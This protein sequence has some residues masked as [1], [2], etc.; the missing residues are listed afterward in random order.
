MKKV[1][2]LLW[3]VFLFIGLLAYLSAK[4]YSR[5]FGDIG[6]EAVLFTLLNGVEG[7]ADS[8]IDEY[9]K[10]S[11]YPSF[12]ITL[13]VFLVLIFLLGISVKAHIC[14]IVN[15]RYKLTIFP[16]PERLVTFGILA[17][18]VI[19][20]IRGANIFG[21]SDWLK[22]KREQ[23]TIY[24]D[25]YVVPSVKNVIF[26]G[27]KRNLIYIYL[28]SMENTFFSIEEGGSRPYNVI[29]ELY[30]LAQDNVNF[31]Q[32]DRVGGGLN[33]VAAIWT[34]GAMTAQTSGLPSKWSYAPETDRN[35]I[36]VKY[37]FLPGAHTLCDILHENGY[38]QALMVGSDSRF[39]GRRQ[40]YE[41]HGTDKVYDLFTARED[42][43]IPSDYSAWWGFEDKYL[44]TYAK[45]EL[46][47]IAEME[48][49]FAFT[50]LTADTHHVGGYVCDLCQEQYEEQYENVFACSSRQVYEFV[51]WLQEQDFYADTTIILTGDHISMDY[52]FIERN[53]SPDYVR[54]VYNCFINPAIEPT[55]TKNREFTT[56]D[57]FPTTL[58]AIGVTVKGDRLGLG[59]DLFSGTP[60][61]LERYGLEWWDAEMAKSSDYYITHF[62]IGGK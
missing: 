49:P 42:G 23:T 38:Y 21:L 58:T 15:E 62:A 26:N 31:S 33:T 41:Q 22:M 8:M 11:L 52:E 35:T 1:Q 10:G 20:L 28:E 30:K 4:W 7:S 5:V 60:T 6:F 44:F 57:M 48:Q 37:P 18:S 2:R 25:E 56:M 3:A 34:T 46:L 9:L 40:L 29:P 59:T 45:Q 16:L 47:K 43:I 55:N 13:A 36:G 51:Q 24:Q 39:G 50:M 54:R 17:V 32:N 19:F 27:E 53:I 12:C 61:L 14:L